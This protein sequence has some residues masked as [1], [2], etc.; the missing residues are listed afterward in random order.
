MTIMIPPS[1]NIRLIPPITARECI[2]QGKPMRCLSD[3]QIGF[4][5]YRSIDIGGFLDEG[6]FVAYGVGVVV[7]CVLHLLFCVYLFII[8]RT[9][10]K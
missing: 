7:D 6:T 5:H 4:G 9:L 3:T 2:I 10:L 8:K 1:L